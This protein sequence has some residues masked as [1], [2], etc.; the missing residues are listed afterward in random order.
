MNEILLFLQEQDPIL[1]SSI[2]EKFSIF[3]KQFYLQNDENRR[4]NMMMIYDLINN[5]IDGLDQKNAGKFYFL[6]NSL[7][8]A[9]ILVFP[10]TLLKKGIP[11]FG[12]LYSYCNTIFNQHDFSISSPSVI[13]WVK[14]LIEKEEKTA[15]QRNMYSIENINGQSII[16]PKMASFFANILRNLNSKSQLHNMQFSLMVRILD[17]LVQHLQV[18]QSIFIADMVLQSFSLLLNSLDPL[19][20]YLFDQVTTLWVSYYPYLKNVDPNLLQNH[21]D[22][23]SIKFL[24]ISTQSM[25]TNRINIDTV[26]KLLEI[27]NTQTQKLYVFLFLYRCF[28][29]NIN[30]LES[31]ENGWNSYLKNDNTL[32]LLFL[33]LLR[34]QL[35]ALIQS[36]A[37]ISFYR[38]SLIEQDHIV[39][40]ISFSEQQLFNCI[41]THSVD[42]DLFTTIK[43]NIANSDD[44]EALNKQQIDNTIRIIDQVNTVFRYLK[45]ALS[46]F[47]NIDRSPSELSFSIIQQTI[48]SVFGLLTAFI[49][50]YSYKRLIIKSYLKN[51]DLK[52]ETYIHYC[53]HQII[54]MMPISIISNIAEKTS[55]IVYSASS[56]GFLS[57]NFVVS[58]ILFATREYTECTRSYSMFCEKLIQNMIILTQNSISSFSYSFKSAFS[59]YQWCLFIMRMSHSLKS[60]QNFSRSF[61]MLQIYQKRMISSLMFGYSRCSSQ[62]LVIRM[63]NWLIDLFPFPEL[64]QSGAQIIQSFSSSVDKLAQAESIITLNKIFKDN[65]K[66]IQ[67]QSVSEI[68]LS[69]LQS[70][71]PSIIQIASEFTQNTIRNDP[72]MQKADNIKEESLKPLVEWFNSMGFLNSNQIENVFDFLPHNISV[73]S[74]IFLKQYNSK[75]KWLFRDVFFDIQSF[76]DGFSLNELQDDYQAFDYFKIIQIFLEVS[77]Q[78]FGESR[79]NPYHSYYLLLFQMIRLS[80]LSSVS[81]IIMKELKNQI[82]LFL[83]LLELHSC[84]ALFLVLAKIAGSHSF[85]YAKIAANSMRDFIEMAKERK[86][87]PRVIAQLMTDILHSQNIDTPFSSSVISFSIILQ[88]YP[89]AI[90]LDHFKS[91]LLASEAHHP[92][93]LSIELLFNDLL[94]SFLNSISQEEKIEF[95]DFSFSSLGYMAIASCRFLISR[96]KKTGIRINTSYSSID[97]FR[98]PFIV[99]QQLA[100][101]FA[102]G[103]RGEF[104]ISPILI[105][106]IGEYLYGKED[107]SFFIDRVLRKC[108]FIHSLVSNELVFSH[109]QTDQL[110]MSS[111]MNFLCNTLTSKY[112]PILTLSKKVFRIIG[113]MNPDRVSCA[114]QITEYCNNPERIFSFFSPQAERILFYSRICRLF[115]HKMPYRVVTTFFLA[116]FEYSTFVQ[117]RMEKFFINYVAIL[118]FLSNEQYITSENVKSMVFQSYRDG[119]FFSFYLSTVINLFIHPEIPFQSASKKYVAKFLSF[120]SDQTIQH[121]NEKYN[122][123]GDSGNFLCSI[124]E[125]D[126]SKRLLYS[127][128]GL[129]ISDISIGLYSLNIVKSI[130]LIE[131]YSNEPLLINAIDSLY[132][133]YVDSI[134][135]YT[136]TNLS[137]SF[138]VSLI[139]IEILL[140][141]LDR[142]F[143]I[144]RAIKFLI[145]FIHKEYRI[146]SLFES[147]FHIIK[148][149]S[150]VDE[151]S[152]IIRSFIKDP[153]RIDLFALVVPHIGRFCLLNEDSKMFLLDKCID[154]L[155]QKRNY[156]SLPC[157]V[158]LCG[159][160]MPNEDC[161]NLL[162]DAM[163]N[164]MDSPSQLTMVSSM[165]LFLLLY[166]NVEFPIGLYSSLFIQVFCHSSFFN[167]PYS[168]FTLDFLST[169][170]DYINIL[171]FE[172]IE[173]FVNFIINLL[174]IN[175]IILLKKIIS[176]LPKLVSILPFSFFDLLFL[177]IDAIAK[178]E[179]SNGSDCS[180]FSLSEFIIN[181]ISYIDQTL[182]NHFFD[183]MFSISKVGIQTSLITE[184]FASS[185]CSLI[186]MYPSRFDNTILDFLNSRD[187]DPASVLFIYSAA[188]IVVPEFLFNHYLDLIESALVFPFQ[189]KHFVSPNLFEKLASICLSDSRYC[190]RFSVIIFSILLSFI[191]SLSS[192]SFSIFILYLSSY[193]K[194]AKDL[195]I[196]S[197]IK[198]VI[199]QIQRIKE[200]IEN[201]DQLFGFIFS[202]IQFVYP[203]DQHDYIE[204]IMEML[205]VY[206]EQLINFYQILPNLFLFSNLTNQSRRHILRS[207]VINNDIITYFDSSYTLSVLLTNFCDIELEIMAFLAIPILSSQICSIN[208]RKQILRIINCKLPHDLHERFVFF[209]DYLPLYC[210]DDD[211]FPF[212]VFLLLSSNSEEWFYFQLFS[213]SFCHSVVP[214]FCSIFKI[215]EENSIYCIME[216]LLVHISRNDVKCSVCLRAIL[217]LLYVS[218]FR[219]NTSLAERI[220]K[221]TDNPQL[222]HFFLEGTIPSSG[223]ILYTSPSDFPF[224]SLF[225]NHNSNE[226]AAMALTLLNQYKAANTIYSLNTSESNLYNEMRIVNNHYLIPVETG[227]ISESF[228]HPLSNH[229]GEK[230]SFISELSKCLM[231]IQNQHSNL[232]IN[233]LKKKISYSFRKMKCRNRFNI[234]RIIA[235]KCSLILFES[236]NSSER[237]ISVSDVSFMKFLNPVQISTLLKLDHSIR[238]LVP[239][240]FPTI[241]T[242]EPPAL[243]FSTSVS[244]CFNNICGYSSRG[245]LM[246]SKEH[247]DDCFNQFA[248]RILKQSITFID[249]CR[250]ASICSS[251]FFSQPSNEI[252]VPT[253]T[254]YSQILSVKADIAP[255]LRYE[256]QSRIVSLIKTAFQLG[257][258]GILS[259]LSSTPCYQI[260]SPLWKNWLP[261]LFSIPDFHSLP[262]QFHHAIQQTPVLAY[263]ASTSRGLQD[264]SNKSL[265][266]LKRNEINMINTL[267]NSVNSICELDL[268]SRNRQESILKLFQHLTKLSDDE[269][270]IMKET[271]L[272]S[273]STLIDPLNSLFKEDQYLYS[274]IPS[275]Y[276]DIKNLSDYDMM[277]YIKKLSSS[278]QSLDK[279]H[280]NIESLANLFSNSI[281]ILENDLS[282]EKLGR[283]STSFESIGPNLCAIPTSSGSLLIE[284]RENS[285]YSSSI[286]VLYAFQA[287]LRQCY[288][289]NI[290]SI[291]LS[292][293]KMMQLDA[294]I[295]IGSIDKD[296]MSLYSMFIHTHRGIPNTN[297]KS[298]YDSSIIAKAIHHG[299]S[300]SEF[301]FFK[302]QLLSSFSSSI[303]IRHLFKL[304]YPSIEEIMISKFNASSPM[305]STVISPT[306]PHSQPSMRLSPSISSFF[307]PFFKPELITS[308]AAAGHSFLS[309]L[310]ATRASFEMIILEDG[311][312][313]MYSLIN[314]RNNYEESLNSISPPSGLSATPIEGI[315]WYEHIENLVDRAIKPEGVPEHRFNW[316]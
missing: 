309:Q 117:S 98:D 44:C 126:S 32:N 7:F 30:F 170:M 41:K 23:I 132:N 66:S 96:M 156:Q 151:S 263:F 97:L 74:S 270:S 9:L 90:S 274:N 56:S 52:E 160:I 120:F 18:K 213:H 131:G 239:A 54:D 181:Y 93:D 144:S 64:S 38:T 200:R 61:L 86:V 159:T 89:E 257:D 177:K 287:S 222:H 191:E 60:N 288:T 80:R 84:N 184:S 1:L 143:S 209:V 238:K 296:I 292:Y 254:I 228:L 223:Y 22:I 219:I 119:S 110:I 35:K 62:V 137:S 208:T 261:L 152:S 168:N 5:P 245:L 106:F 99:I 262:P 205:S 19:N 10:S 201:V 43:F 45:P 307:G 240:K 154:E 104:E 12:F 215:N 183:S 315:N 277:E 47:Q 176:G 113:R 264:L 256:A 196:T 105:K 303:T 202:S 112:R 28:S 107:T 249:C 81:D 141:I 115:P 153:I 161:I 21:L 169:G 206:T 314:K 130:S 92:V 145:V 109:L 11:P 33:S 305:M 103:I 76:L 146:P 118:R 171:A 55:K 218:H 265:Y 258:D 282:P 312:E 77:N 250:F 294:K 82:N 188:N 306:E 229:K 42:K 233:Q 85:D 260:E 271:G 95:I 135:S 29:S 192:D 49:I 13:N 251:L 68:L 50:Q 69:A 301:L 186:N 71:I 111:M 129:I 94:K 165:Q 164:M 278:R 299:L 14:D 59:A 198:W 227:S 207:L 267:I 224:P 290:R 136:Q 220:L 189:S 269:I 187:L 247:I 226:K 26:F 4:S 114:R 142:E 83:P 174:K 15:H 133:N 8:S 140:I 6:M 268:Y 286:N 204:T 158:Y 20:T 248:D 179:I 180:L 244:S 225:E 102:C 36:M 311:N 211:H 138:T 122:F 235:L 3:S 46:S 166:N 51:N 67:F 217:E 289:T 281:V 167:G 175:D 283:I 2:C 173:A 272:P 147:Y 148:K 182:L 210:W 241:E 149:H 310:E 266:L 280:S 31:L 234:E 285:C 252:F 216:Q 58:S 212:I 298:S 39:I 155:I 313:S 40:R 101:S 162:F 190:F 100:A 197:F 203:D 163:S 236:K 37:S 230:D 70:R 116:L 157:L 308:I 72:L 78:Q 195:H 194:Y 139:I 231:S 291:T 88:V 273:N 127:F 125:S 275:V 178:K 57:I 297:Y 17:Y 63:I 259:L 276:Y 214:Y 16:T 48:I 237:S 25:F 284:K 79:Q 75:E 242:D 255:L 123:L 172:S 295:Y 199:T 243:L 232:L 34:N 185:F 193:I 87:A 53:F 108:M 121:L 24:R 304:E 73:V 302:S 221:R 253:F 316:I 293:S 300:F 65:Y 134:N 150:T 128:L 279:I 27:C 246:V 91:L 124:I